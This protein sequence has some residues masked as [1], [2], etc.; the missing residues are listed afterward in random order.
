MAP[1]L[2]D[3]STMWA[4]LMSLGGAFSVISG[5]ESLDVGFGAGCGGESTRRR[6]EGKQDHGLTMPLD[7]GRLDCL[8][9]ECRN[10]ALPEGQ[11][12]MVQ[13]EDAD[14]PGTG[15]S[16]PDYMRYL[17]SNAALAVCAHD[18]EFGNVPG[19]R[20]G[21]YGRLLFDKHK[22]CPLAVDFDEEGMPA[23][24]APIEREVRIAKLAVGV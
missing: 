18:K 7:A 14:S 19:G 21:G 1:T 22:A 10:C 17:G 4:V 20:M 5:L 12:R 8:A 9:G 2:T 15:E 3:M 13:L 23:G 16:A 6:D 24:V 11:R